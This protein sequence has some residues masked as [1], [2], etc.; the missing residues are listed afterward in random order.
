M[1]HF[2]LLVVRC[3]SLLIPRVRSWVGRHPRVVRKH[4]VGT[5]HTARHVLRGRIAWRE[6]LCGRRNS[7]V[8]I[9]V[10]VDR[11]GRWEI[12]RH[13]VVPS[14]RKILNRGEYL[15]ISAP[16]SLGLVGN[17]LPRVHSASWRVRFSREFCAQKGAVIVAMSQAAEYLIR[18]IHIGAT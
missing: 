17:L 3:A 12:E 6:C 4:S 1:W 18:R 9:V 15:S 10:F 7:I 13:A 14:T 8:W 2:C 11:C 5:Q 16:L